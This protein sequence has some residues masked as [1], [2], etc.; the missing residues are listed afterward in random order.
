VIGRLAVYVDRDFRAARGTAQLYRAL[1]RTALAEEAEAKARR[2]A[3]ERR[4]DPAAGPA[5]K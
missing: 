4:V 1:G 3:G 2:L 5:T